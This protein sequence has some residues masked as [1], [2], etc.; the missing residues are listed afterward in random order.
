MKNNNLSS[1]NN[2]ISAQISNILKNTLSELF[3]NK[4]NNN[5]N[6]LNDLKNNNNKLIYQRPSYI[7]E[8]N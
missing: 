6:Y 3:G 1:G 4:D 7:N 2:S 5:N 8:T